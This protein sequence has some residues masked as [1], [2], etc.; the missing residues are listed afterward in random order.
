MSD[1]ESEAAEVQRVNRLIDRD[2]LLAVDLPDSLIIFIFILVL[3]SALIA[4]F[5]VILAH[6]AVLRAL[7]ALLVI[8]FHLF[9][10][11]LLSL[12]ALHLFE[13]F[14]RPG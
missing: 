2:I 13:L 10:A 9:V 5:L 3:H 4:A 1:S 14:H 8:S 12:L 11:T 7:F 6:L